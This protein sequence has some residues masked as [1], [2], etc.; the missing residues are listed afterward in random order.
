MQPPLTATNVYAG[1]TTPSELLARPSY[2]VNTETLQHHNDASFDNIVPPGCF[3]GTQDVFNVSEFGAQEQMIPMGNDA[4]DIDGMTVCHGYPMQNPENEFDFGGL[5]AQSIPLDYAASDSLNPNQW[6]LGDQFHGQNNPASDFT[7]N[8]NPQPLLDSDIPIPC[9]QFGCFAT[10][11]RD[12]DRIRHEAA[13]HGINKATYLYHVVGCNKS[14]G[15]GYTRKD[16][17]TEHLWQ[18]HGNLGYVKRT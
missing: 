11:K 3:S 10:F 15:V 5:L 1:W 2:W 14:Q 13:V 6:P 9:H 12:P 7:G 4:G 18:K 17:L 8:L 16:K